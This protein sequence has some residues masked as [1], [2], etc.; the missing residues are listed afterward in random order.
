MIDDR[1]NPMPSCIPSQSRPS[2]NLNSSPLQIKDN[3][4]RCA[5]MAVLMPTCCACSYSRSAACSF[6]W[7]SLQII[8]YVS[9]P[10]IFFT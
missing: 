10:E 4:S 7:V 3:Q 2:V 9:S 6:P 1:S 5:R 8:L